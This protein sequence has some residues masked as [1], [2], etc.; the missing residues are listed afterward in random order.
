VSGLGASP[1]DE[2]ALNAIGLTKRFDDNLAV[3]GLD[4]M[5]AAGSCFGILGPNGAGK[6]TFMRMASCVLEPTAGRLLVLGSDVDHERRRIKARVGVVPQG[7]TLDFVLT[8]EEVLTVHAGYFGV[9]RREARARA[10]R[11][12][13]L[14][15]LREHAGQRA[16]TLSGGM[17]RRL[18]LARALVNEPE[19]LLLDEPTSGLDPQARQAVW[20]LLRHARS[21]GTTIIVTTH[22]IEEAARLC[23]VVAII[24]RGR[25]IA[26]DQPARLVSQSL[27]R[28]AIEVTGIDRAT[29]ESRIGE[30]ERMSTA[31]RGG[32]VHVFVDDAEVT[33]RSLTLAGINRDDTVVRDTSLEDV[34]FLLAGRSIE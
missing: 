11:L 33:L 19:L 9:G 26:C 24:D 20:E 18:L 23:D 31:E 15:D 34:F 32:V 22:Y 28:R 13:D 2:T 17:Q 27:P 10:A 7:M 29:L 1:V 6:T 3:D 8:C 14:L 16:Q 5:V 12:L 4:L 21:Q 30:F 25:V